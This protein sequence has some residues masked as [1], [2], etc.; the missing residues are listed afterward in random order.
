MK[1]KSVR[2]PEDID[3]AIVGVGC[4]VCNFGISSILRLNSTILHPN[5]TSFWD[6]VRAEPA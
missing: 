3:N 6:N 1:V 2:I 5:S 4:Q